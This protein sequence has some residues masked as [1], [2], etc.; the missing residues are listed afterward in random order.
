V[1]RLPLDKLGTLKPGEVAVELRFINTDGET[2]VWMVEANED[3][4]SS[5]R[6]TRNTPLAYVDDGIDV[7]IATQKRTI[8]RLLSHVKF[9]CPQFSSRNGTC[10]FREE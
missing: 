8:D 2:E 6:R 9:H 10:K 7:R 5:I 1:R 3:F 4:L